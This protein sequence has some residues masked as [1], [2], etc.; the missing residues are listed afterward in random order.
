MSDPD[1]SI[2]P[3]KEVQ[4]NLLYSFI[5][6]GL[7]MGAV[8]P[9]FTQFFVEWRPGYAIWFVISCLL[10]GTVV[11]VINFQL[12]NRFLRKR[13]GKIDIVVRAIGD[14]DFTQSCNIEAHGV[15]GEIVA[16]IDAM[17]VKLRTTVAAIKHSA[18]QLSDGAQQ[19]SDTVHASDQ[20]LQQQR[21]ETQDLATAIGE[22]AHATQGVASSATQAVEAAFQANEDTRDGHHVVSQTIQSINHVADEVEKA[23]QVIR[24]LESDSEKIGRVLD[25]IRAITEQTNLLALNAAIEAAR[26]G[27]H[28]RGFSV[29]AD[30]VRTLASRTRESTQEIKQMIEQLQMAT[31]NAV[32]VMETSCTQARSSVELAAKTDESLK[33]IAAAV[34]TIT[35][36]NKQIASVAD[37]QNSTAEMLHRNSDHILSGTDKAAALAQ[38]ATTTAGELSTQAAALQRVMAP[39]KTR[40]NGK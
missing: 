25:V 29:V 35:D 19:L 1:S 36:K 37:A 21:A 40:M 30:E 6:F 14:G 10:A 5:G 13:L 33:A 22:L 11:G 9:V 15:V 20:G 18:A 12:M 32:T 26:A 39:F 3:A 7:A 34:N 8:F 23:A 31:T 2:P 38:Q 24:N 4:S 27:E 16:G 17:V 28:G